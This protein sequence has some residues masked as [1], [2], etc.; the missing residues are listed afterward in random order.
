MLSNDMAPMQ[1]NFYFYAI[2][3]IIMI[4]LLFYACK[5]LCRHKTE[6]WLYKHNWYLDGLEQ[7][8]E[9]STYA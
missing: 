1:F 6:K 4:A 5:Y 2:V 9:E 3:I 7:N 8:L